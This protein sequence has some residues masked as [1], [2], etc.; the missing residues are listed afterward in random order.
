MLTTM[1]KRIGVLLVVLLIFSGCKQSGNKDADTLATINSEPV[2]AAEMIL[3]MLQV[4]TSFEEIGGEDVWDTE[5]FS[6][7]KT[8]EQVAKEGAL[9]NLIKVKISNGKA[10]S[11][12]V[13]L[14]PAQI[15]ET[16]QAARQYFGAMDSALIEKY[17]IDQELVTRSFLE[18]RLSTAVNASITGQ[19]EP[20]QAQIETAMMENADY[21]KIKGVTPKDALTTVSVLHVMTSTVTTDTDGNQVELSEEAQQA[22]YDKIVKAHGQALAGEDFIQVVKE[23]SEEDGS[24]DSQEYKLS[25]ALLDDALKQ[26]FADVPIG[27]ITDVAK[28]ESGYHFFKV[29]DI[30]VPTQQEIEGYES[31]FETMEAKLR[32]EVVKTLKTQAFDEIYDEW[33]AEAAIEL[34]QARWKQMS[35]FELGM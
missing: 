8:A 17:G 7:G 16:T 15:E 31:Q 35:I 28:S 32:D 34:D 5:D 29:M 4:K 9:E 11:L 1:S 2:S 26:V 3:Y 21:A 14:T 6:G 33:K 24:D 12:G 25:V 18:F 22:A 30:S 27:G 13:S 19:Y 23:Y 20:S 10:E